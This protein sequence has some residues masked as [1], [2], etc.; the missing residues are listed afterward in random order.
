MKDCK[1]TGRSTFALKGDVSKA[2]RRVAVAESDWGMQACSLRPGKV[3]LNKVGTFGVASAAYWW[4]RMSSATAR[5]TLYVLGREYV[6]QLLYADDFTWAVQGPQWQWNLLLSIL[7]LELM[8][9]PFAWHKFGGGFA[10]EWVGYYLDYAH[11]SIGISEGR[12][13][14]LV[15]WLKDVLASGGTRGIDME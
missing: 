2:H 12:T 11:F 7:L 15:R 9:T 14:W 1:T 13:R 6:W 3:W 8:G 5:L 10:L 4:S